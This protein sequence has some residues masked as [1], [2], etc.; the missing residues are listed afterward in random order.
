[1]ETLESPTEMR[2]IIAQHFARADLKNILLCVWTCL[3]LLLASAF[4]I[5]PFPKSP[6]VCQKA[7]PKGYLDGLFLLAWLCYKIW[8][9]GTIVCMYIQTTDKLT[10]KSACTYIMCMSAHGRCNLL[11]NCQFC[12]Q[13]NDIVLMLADCRHSHGP[14]CM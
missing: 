3:T 4:E 14:V 1:M 11:Q 10:C 7:S 2:L 8:S 6:L 12:I 9:M 5:L 13:S